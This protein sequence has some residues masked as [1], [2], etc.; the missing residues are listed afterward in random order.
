MSHIENIVMKKAKE[1]VYKPISKVNDCK[2][3]TWR[4][5]EANI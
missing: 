2:I 3:I 4:Y 1:V 5:G